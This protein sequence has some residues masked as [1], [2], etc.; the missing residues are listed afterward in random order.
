[1]KALGEL[2]VFGVVAAAL[3]YGAIFLVLTAWAYYIGW[4]LWI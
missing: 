1:M 2:I 3:V 4:P